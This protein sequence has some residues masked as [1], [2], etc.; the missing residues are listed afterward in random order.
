MIHRHQNANDKNNFSYITNQNG[1][2]RRS[3]QNILHETQKSSTTL[4][5][6]FDSKAENC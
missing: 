6:R 5:N 2:F 1:T 3:F 4:R